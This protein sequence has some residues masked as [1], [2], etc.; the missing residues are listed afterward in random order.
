[1]YEI[2]VAETKYKAAENTQHTQHLQTVLSYIPSLGVQNFETKMFIFTANI[3]YQSP[4]FLIIRI[5]ISPEKAASVDPEIYRLVNDAQV[6]YS[7][8][9]K[10]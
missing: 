5:N 4:W 10:V 2:N 1:M 3:S 6:I 9:V 8:K 7:W